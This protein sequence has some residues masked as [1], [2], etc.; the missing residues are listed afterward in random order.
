LIVPGWVFTTDGRRNFLRGDRV[1]PLATR[2]SAR[3]YNGQVAN[4]LYFWAAMLCPDDDRTIF[5]DPE[6]GVVLSRHYVMQHV[7]AA[8]GPTTAPD[9]IDLLGADPVDLIYADEEDIE[10]EMAAL[11]AEFRGDD[12]PRGQELP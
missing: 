12:V 3:E 9:E 8:E 4:H 5:P 1:G 10:D 2:R 11:A 7:A 6:T